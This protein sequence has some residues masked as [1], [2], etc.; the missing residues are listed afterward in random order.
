MGDGSYIPGAP[1][2]D[3]ARKRNQNLP[4]MGG[5]FN[6]VNLHVYHYAGNNPVK[7]I[8]PDGE[9][10]FHGG[11]Y[12]GWSEDAPQAQIP[13][14]DPL[15]M[16]AIGLGFVIDATK[17]DFGDGYL[18]LWKGDY[19]GFLLYGI[20][21]AGG[22]IEFFD[23]NNNIIKG[24]QLTERI[25]LVNVTMEAFLKGD[26]SLVAGYS[27]LSGWVT[28]FDPYKSVLPGMMYT[29]NTFEFRDVEYA[30]KFEANIQRSINTGKEREMAEYYYWN[31]GERLNVEREGNRVTITWGLE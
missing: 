7:L 21:G 30:K 24:A 22:E 26:N 3:E 5:V 25:G 8:D 13:Y 27:E 28:A 1:I 16:L 4:G 2:N 11:R 6:Y 23:Y 10:V 29:R 12:P 14:T 19:N 9:A 15:D 20:G 31:H 18:R 17:L